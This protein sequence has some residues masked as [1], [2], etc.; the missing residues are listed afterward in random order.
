MLHLHDEAVAV[1]SYRSS[2]I[3][4]AEFDQIR[5]LPETAAKR[6]LLWELYILKAKDRSTFYK[7]ITI[8]CECGNRELANSLLKKLLKNIKIT[9]LSNDIKTDLIQNLCGEQAG[10]LVNGNHRANVYL[11]IDFCI[12]SGIIQVEGGIFCR[13]LNSSE[14]EHALTKILRTDGGW[15]TLQRYFEMQKMHDLT[16]VTLMELLFASTMC[17]VSNITQSDWK[18][19]LTN[20][21]ICTY[22]VEN[23]DVSSSIIPLLTAARILRP[24]FDDIAVPNKFFMSIN[25]KPN[26]QTLLNLLN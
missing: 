14:M 11:A 8:L 7:I 16:T 19:L 13:T 5:K 25:C 2:F 1:S 9:D 18:M 6:K 24:Q 23:V 10:K 22:I 3:S 20:P 17:P 12:E 26:Y 4:G 15:E 21:Q